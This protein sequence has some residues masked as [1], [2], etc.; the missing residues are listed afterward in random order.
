MSIADSSDDHRYE[1][2]A[3]QINESFETVK[4]CAT[5]QGERPTQKILDVLGLKLGKPH[6]VRYDYEE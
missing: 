1:H 6:Y 3:A 5:I 2:Y 4:R